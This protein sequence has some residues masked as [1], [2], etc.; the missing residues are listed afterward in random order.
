MM[1]E[2]VSQNLVVVANSFN[3][4]IFSSRWLEKQGVIKS[5]EVVEPEMLTPV[6]AKITTKE[7]GLLVVPERL[8][9]TFNK[10]VK[11]KKSTI[12]NVV[13]KIINELKH[14]P[15]SAAGFNYIFEYWPSDSG[16]FIELN[17][18][19]LSNYNPIANSVGKGAKT[20]YGFSCI[21]KVNGFEMRLDV[22]PHVKSKKEFL[23]FN[24]NFNRM[25]HDGDSKVQELTDVCD[26]FD[27]IEKYCSNILNDFQTTWG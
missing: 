6:A 21:E 26:E 13:M 25:L 3:P 7:Y 24:F 18:K 11:T 1:F 22:K 10:D 8:Q 15:F 5:D 9:L 16:K 12:D 27:N 14:T 19:L 20:R 23:L 17:Q 2:I 4:S